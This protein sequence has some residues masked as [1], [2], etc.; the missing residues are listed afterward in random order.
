VGIV[1]RDSLRGRGMAND[2]GVGAA[3]TGESGTVGK[4]SRGV[5]RRLVFDIPRR[6]VSKVGLRAV[7]GTGGNLKVGF[8]AGADVGSRGLICVVPSSPSLEMSDGA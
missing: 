1:A 6:D 4:M 7:A 5:G 8:V 2:V 3:F